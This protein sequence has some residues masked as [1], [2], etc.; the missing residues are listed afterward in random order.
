M[1]A[2]R[3]VRCAGYATAKSCFLAGWSVLVENYIGRNSEEKLDFLVQDLGKNTAW[4]VIRG[5]T[6]VEYVIAWEC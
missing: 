3:R 2:L 6:D 5:F 1:Y 4:L